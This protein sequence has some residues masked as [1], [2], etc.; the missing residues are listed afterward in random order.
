MRVARIF[1][2]G[3]ALMLEGFGQTPQVRTIEP[4]NPKPGDIVSV[5]GIFL[6]SAKVDD[7]FLTDHRFDLKVKLIEQTPT[8]LK[9]R[10]PPFIRAGRHQLLLQTTGDTPKLLEQPVF[11]VVD[12]DDVVMAARK[13]SLN[14]AADAA[15]QPQ[16]A[17]KR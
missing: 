8:T 5:T 1:V 17:V 10:I 15:P 11:V 12:P 3:A 14:S 4:R 16:E 7:A 6:E 9:F 2:V 13:A